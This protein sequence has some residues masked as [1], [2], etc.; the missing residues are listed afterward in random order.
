MDKYKELE[1]KLRVIYGDKVEHLHDG[2]FKCRTIDKDGEESI[3]T[4]IEGVDTIYHENS[5]R[6]IQSPYELLRNEGM[7]LVSTDNEQLILKLNKTGNKVVFRLKGKGWQSSTRGSIYFTKKITSGDEDDTEKY[8]KEIGLD[9]LK[10]L[11]CDGEVEVKKDLTLYRLICYNISK[12]KVFWDTTISG[13]KFKREGFI[14]LTLID[15]VYDGKTRGTLSINAS[16]GELQSYK[17][18]Q[19]ANARFKAK[20]ERSLNRGWH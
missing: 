11:D 20:V 9:T 2:I 1:L 12:N 10:L 14:W 7:I 15:P 18:I 4:I 5:V 6:F 8:G 13:I 16:S 17:R 19:I 3:I